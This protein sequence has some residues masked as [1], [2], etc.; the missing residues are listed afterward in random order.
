MFWAPQDVFLLANAFSAD[1]VNNEKAT[2]LVC[3]QKRG[4]KRARIKN[5]IRFKT[6]TYIYFFVFGDILPFLSLFNLG[7]DSD[8]AESSWELFSFGKASLRIC[9]G[10]NSQPFLAFKYGFKTYVHPPKSYTCADVIK[11]FSLVYFNF[12]VLVL[13]HCSVSTFVVYSF[14][15][16]RLHCSHWSCQTFQRMTGWLPSSIPLT[17]TY[18]GADDS[19]YLFLHFTLTVCAS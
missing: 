6:K 1:R 2:S 7:S 16:A 11:Q 9:E 18:A 15:W 4:L 17:L 3:G 19:P 14:N 10:V 8:G 13:T 12:I 5:A